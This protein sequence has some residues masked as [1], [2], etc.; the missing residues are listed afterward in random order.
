MRSADL[1]SISGVMERSTKDSGITTKCTAMA[2]YGGQMERNIL[3][4]SKR[5]K[6]MVMESSSGGMVENMK[7]NG[8]EES[9]TVQE[10]IEMPK[11]RRE[12]VF[13]SKERELSGSDI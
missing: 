9:N 11:E 8:L 3:V 13:G 4:N 6:D 10:Y 2:N 5:T 12:R 1:A 7:E